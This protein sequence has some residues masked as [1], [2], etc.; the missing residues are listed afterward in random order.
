[1]I[2]MSEIALE[3]WYHIF[4][5]LFFPPLDICRSLRRV[6]LDQR[7]KTRDSISDS[8]FVQITGYSDPYVE[9]F[10]WTGRWIYVRDMKEHL[11]RREMSIWKR[12]KGFRPEGVIIAHAN[13]LTKVVPLSR[14]DISD[15]V[16]PNKRG[17]LPVGTKVVLLSSQTYQRDDRWKEKK[18][19]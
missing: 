14:S 17:I 1:M 15:L 2:Q 4:S 10:L 6:A 18:S 16:K 5:Y 7:K 3:V 19:V 13:T 8:Q 9:M 12:T 11:L